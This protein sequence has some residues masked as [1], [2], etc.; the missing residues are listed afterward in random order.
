M[1]A[2]TKKI[3]VLVVDDSAV[4]RR[5][6]QGLL[7]RDPEIEVVATAIDGDF[8]LNKVDQLTP[9]VITLDIDMPRMDGLTALGRILARRYVPV[10]MLSSLTTEGA[11]LTMKALEMG[12]VEF[13]CKPRG[14]AQV[15]EMAEEL[16]TK[17]KAAGRAKTTEPVALPAG[18][19]GYRHVRPSPD[20]AGDRVVAIGASSGGPHALR[21]LLPKIPGDFNA[22]IV[23]VQHMPESFTSMLAR[24]LDEICEIEVREAKQGDVVR[25]GCALIAPGNAHMRLRKSGRGWEVV[26]ERG[27]LVNGHMP[28]V[29]VM[30]SSVAAECGPRSTAVIMTGMGSDGATAMG[31]VRRA[32]GHTVA[33]DEESCAIF[34]MPKVAI[35]KGYIEKVVPLAELADYLV[36][37]VGRAAVPE[38]IRHAE[39]R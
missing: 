8:A 22:G 3:R 36:S 18:L 39:S 2:D 38:V 21:Q 1:G 11:A 26:L 13:V 27:A 30:F 19:R 14:A 10:I 6:I 31:E 9:D 5:M 4:M 16:L 34:G 25:R 32:G 17:V 37:V 28:S 29:D 23:I 15:S 35:N 12:A 7:E 20:C 24:W 33:Q